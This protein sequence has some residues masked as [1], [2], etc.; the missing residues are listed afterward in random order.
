MKILFT[1]FHYGRGGGHDTYIVA[2]ARALAKRH[3]VFVAA[4][5]SSRLFDHASALRDVTTLAMEF[6]AKLKDVARMRAAWRAL[7]DLLERERFD[8]IHVNGSPDHRLLLLVMLFWKGPRPRI[9]FTKH[10]S[11]EIKGDLLTRVRAKRATDDVIA[12]SDSTAELVRRSVYA[13][14]PLTVI[15]NGIDIAKFEPRDAEATAE[16]RRALIGPDASGRL[17]F[18]TV[19]GFDSYKGTMDLIAAVAALPEALREAVM[20][21][22]VGTEP[23]A[24]QRQTIDALGMR[25]K[26]RVVGFVENVPDYIATF[27]VGFVLSYAVETVSFACREMM[28]MG[29]PVIITRYAGL[30]ENV[31][32]GV[33]GWIVGPRDVGQMTAIVQK[34]IEDRAMLPDIG[35]RARERAV[36][37]FSSELFIEQTEAVYRRTASGRAG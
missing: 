21:V 14:C 36:R 8:V 2:I 17:V 12:V 26:V 31:D 30:P 32:D 25:D 20:V 13:H 15:K 24:E 6:P 18:G 29:K 7:R 22:V 37:E 5:G 16:A 3:R 33:D 34:I 23:N 9:V 10:N 35:A 4:P 19:T 27:D 28:A 1:N 11:I